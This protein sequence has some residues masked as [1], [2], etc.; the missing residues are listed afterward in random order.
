MDTEKIVIDGKSD[1]LKII[2]DCIYLN[3]RYNRDRSPDITPEGWKTIFGN[4]VD[5]YEVWYQ[6]DKIGSTGLCP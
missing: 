5:K 1:I 3:Y 4:K 2:D 6:A